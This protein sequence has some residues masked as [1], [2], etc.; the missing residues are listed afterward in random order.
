MNSL[1][2]E[3]VATRTSKHKLQITAPKNA[4][5]YQ[6]G[7]AW[8]WILGNGVPSNGQRVMVGTGASE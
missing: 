8:L 4:A 7:F 5:R 6:P 3:V 1:L 2:V